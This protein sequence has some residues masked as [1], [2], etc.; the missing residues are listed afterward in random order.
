[1]LSQ[2]RCFKPPARELQRRDLTESPVA[3]RGS[4]YLFMSGTFVTLYRS[5]FSSPLSVMEPDFPSAK[6]GDCCKDEGLIEAS[7]SP[8]SSANF[9]ISKARTQNSVEIPHNS[10]KRAA[11]WIDDWKPETRM[12]GNEGRDKLEFF[13]RTKELFHELEVSTRLLCF[14]S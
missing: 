8:R 3:R 13:N 9:I 1:M 4:L 10:R 12:V 7:R 11:V 2:T 14:K 5:R 6:D